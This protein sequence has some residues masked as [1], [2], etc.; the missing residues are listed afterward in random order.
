MTLDS[1]DPLCL[2]GVWPKL[3]HLCPGGAW[4]GPHHR[5]DHEVWQHMARHCLSPS[6]LMVSQRPAG[7]PDPGPPSLQ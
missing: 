3:P 7:G 5:A 1:Q 6:A 4:P 2:Q